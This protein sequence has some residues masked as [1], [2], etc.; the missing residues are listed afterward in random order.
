MLKKDIEDFEIYGFE[1]ELV[2]V[3]LILISNAKDALTE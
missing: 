3:L 2:Q 1:N